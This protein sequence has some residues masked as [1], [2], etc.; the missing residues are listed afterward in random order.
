LQAPHVLVVAL[1]T[2]LVTGQSEL[3]PHTLV[4]FTTL[5]TGALIE[6]ALVFDGEH[7]SHRPPTHAGRSGLEHASVAAVPRSPLHALQTCVLTSHMGVEAGHSAS[8]SHPHF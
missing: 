6:Q 3:E 2:G 5:H 4:L 1:Q 8:V 7:C